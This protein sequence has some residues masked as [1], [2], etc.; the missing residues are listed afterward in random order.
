[1]SLF[2]ASKKPHEEEE[3]KEEYEDFLT[4]NVNGLKDLTNKHRKRSVLH[5]VC[6]QQKPFFYLLQKKTPNFNL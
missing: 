2:Q 1:M 4:K 3:E 5:Q 6:D